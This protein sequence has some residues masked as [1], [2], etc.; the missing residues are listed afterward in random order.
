L[1]TR[2]DQKLAEHQSKADHK[3]LRALRDAVA[4]RIA[5]LSR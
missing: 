4:N 5:S 1:L 3:Q 2:L